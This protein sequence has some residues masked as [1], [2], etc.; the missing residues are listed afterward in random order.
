MCLLPLT[1]G[2]SILRSMDLWHAAHWAFSLYST[3]EASMHASQ[4]LLGH[5]IRWHKEPRHP[6]TIYMAWQAMQKW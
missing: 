4:L 3:Q 1:T 5:T 6:C 2:S